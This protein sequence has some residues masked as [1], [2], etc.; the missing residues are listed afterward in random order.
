M[1][2]VPHPLQGSIRRL[3]L[4]YSLVRA[5]LGQGREIRCGGFRRWNAGEISINCAVAN[6]TGFPS[7]LCDPDNVLAFNHRTRRSEAST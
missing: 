6:A 5:L 1:K 2:T 3:L 4:F 7:V